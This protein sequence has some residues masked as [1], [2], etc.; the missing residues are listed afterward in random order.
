MITIIHHAIKP[1]V[2]YTTCTMIQSCGPIPTLIHM[3][4]ASPVSV[5]AD[6]SSGV[7]HSSP[8]WLLK[9]LKCGY[10]TQPVYL[11]I[12][13]LPCLDDMGVSLNTI[14]GTQEHVMCQGPLQYV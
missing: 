9:K 2:L 11:R 10:I 13:C 1:Y 3:A 4:A 8:G 14:L 6:D 5:T 12:Q 7:A